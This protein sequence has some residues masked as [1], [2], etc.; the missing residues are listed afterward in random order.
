MTFAAREESRTLGQPVAL[1][2]FQYGEGS[3]QYFG[4]TDAEQAIGHGGK[5]YVPIPITMGSVKSSGAPDKQSI[6]VRTPQTADLAELFRL[7]PPSQVVT[8]VRREGH[9][10]DPDAQFLVTW[11]GRVLGHKRVDD[12][13]IYTVES[14]GTAMRR[15]LLRRHYMY[16]CPHVLY[17][18]ECQASKG[19]ATVSKTALAVNGATVTLA[20]NWAADALKEKYVGGLVEWTG[21][22]GMKETRS[23]LKIKGADKDQLLL[24]GLAKD[25]VAGMSIDVVLGCNHQAGLNDDCIQLH[26]N[27]L[28]FGGQPWIPTKNPIGLKNTFY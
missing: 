23:I 4:Y 2:H 25:M 5:T 8:L 15:T 1:Y 3:G 17:G 12:E 24:D 18:P 13:A 20:S 27:I 22:S 7:H 6:E 10:G 9:I 21:L 16:G 11:T 19:A 26:D 14:L 28:N